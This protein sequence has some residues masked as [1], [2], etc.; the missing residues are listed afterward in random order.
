MDVNIGKDSRMTTLGVLNNCSL[1]GVA[2]KFRGDSATAAIRKCLTVAGTR[3]EAEVVGLAAGAR[4]LAVSIKVEVT[5]NRW[6]SVS[7]LSLA[8]WP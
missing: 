2:V 6:S 3:E 7:A 8:S 1:P 5:A 4:V